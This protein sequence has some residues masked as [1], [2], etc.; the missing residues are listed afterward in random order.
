MRQRLSDLLP[1]EE[2]TIIKIECNGEIG[3]KLADMGFVSGRKVLMKC[4]ALLRDPIK[5][6]I[7]YDLALRRKEADYI[8]VKDI[9]KNENEKNQ[10]QNRKRKRHGQKSYL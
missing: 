5:I 9:Q 2:A 8:I 7:G 4:Y 3:K 10:R 6:N 1:G